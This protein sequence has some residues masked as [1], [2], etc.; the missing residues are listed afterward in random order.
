MMRLISDIFLGLRSLFSAIKIIRTNPS[1]L[2][3]SSIVSFVALLLSGLGIY[4][5]LEFGPDITKWFW[6]L[7][8]LNEI[9]NSADRSAFWG[10]VSY[11]G[12]TWAREFLEWASMFVGMLA[13]LVILPWLVVLLGFPLCIPLSEKTDA[14]LGGQ[15]AEHGLLKSIR[16]SVTSIFLTTSIGVT[17][18]IL[19]YVLTFVPIVGVIFTL[20]GAF[21]WPQFVL[22]YAVYENSLDRRGLSFREKIAFLRSRLLAS[23]FVGAQTQL[24]IGIPILNL[25]GLP[26]A[27]VAGAVAVRKIEDS[28]DELPSSTEPVIDVEVV[29]PESPSTDDS[30]NPDDAVPEVLAEVEEAIVLTDHL[31]DGTE[32]VVD[33]EVV[34]PEPPSTDDSRNPDDAAPEVLA[35]AEDALI[36]A[37]HLPDSTEPVVDV[38]V[39]S[40]EPLSTDVS[41]NSDNA[42]S[43]V[44]TEEEDVLTIDGVPATES[45]DSPLD[46]SKPVSE[47]DSGEHALPLKVD[48]EDAGHKS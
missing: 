27:V 9:E 44:P 8:G 12:L 24:L 35:D 18:T 43:A 13:A 26:L 2:I 39:V 23:W 17:V 7:F 29:S 37:D 48:T 15:P 1:V 21:I 25:V 32:A 4:A 5:A 3:F 31:P 42:A 16:L 14:I 28:T 34:P 10:E 19:L 20:L 45:D 11:R 46:I 30:S 47:Q 22:S 38:A 33:V 6:E 41:K 36:L 40:S